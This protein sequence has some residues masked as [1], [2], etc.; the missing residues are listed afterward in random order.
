MYSLG[1]TGTAVLAIVAGDIDLTEPKEVHT[2]LA[3]RKPQSPERAAKR[4]R[5]A[6]LKAS[7]PGMNRK[8]RKR[9]ARVSQEAK[10]TP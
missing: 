4:A 2:P 10:P 3:N 1:A 8:A 6:E 5:M 7:N 9:A